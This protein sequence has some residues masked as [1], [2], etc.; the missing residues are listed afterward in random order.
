MGWRRLVRRFWGL[1]GNER[2]RGREGERR[3]E[4]E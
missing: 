3:G 4:T 1:W 2:E